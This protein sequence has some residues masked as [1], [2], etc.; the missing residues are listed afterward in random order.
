[1]E[2]SD[3]YD[4][5]TLKRSTGGDE[6]FMKHMIKLFID[7]APKQLGE[8]QAAVDSQ[9]WPLLGATAHKIKSSIRG[10]GIH[11]LVDDALSLEQDGK[12]QQNLDTVTER[13]ATFE[14]KLIVTIEFLSKEL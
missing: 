7:Q 9:D 3:F 10:M 11:S 2:A 14:A 1:M 6:Q 12:T 8:M 13:L 4:L 5:E